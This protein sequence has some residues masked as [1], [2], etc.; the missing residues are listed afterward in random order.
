[1]KQYP[2]TSEKL[3]ANQQKLRLETKQRA[4]RKAAESGQAL[5]PRWFNP[6]NVPMG[7]GL[8]YVSG[9]MCK[10][11]WPSGSGRGVCLLCIC[12]NQG[13]RRKGVVMRFS[14]HLT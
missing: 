11:A 12:V 10:T 6:C 5:E 1:M 2:N 3:Q 14:K 4:A 13:R 8:A 7:E 9:W